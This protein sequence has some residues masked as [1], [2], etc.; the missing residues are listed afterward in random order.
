M[1]HLHAFQNT[2]DRLKESRV[3]IVP[4]MPDVRKD[5][6]LYEHHYKSAKGE[7]FSDDGKIWVDANGNPVGK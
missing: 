6:S 1:D 3:P 5:Q 4:G 7:I 2:V